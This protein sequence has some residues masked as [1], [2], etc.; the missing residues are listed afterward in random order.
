MFHLLLVCIC[1]LPNYPCFSSKLD[2]WN[3]CALAFMVMSV[4]NCGLN[5]FVVIALATLAIQEV[6]PSF[7]DFVFVTCC[8]CLTHANA[9]A[10]Q[11]P[12]YIEFWASFCA[13]L[14]LQF[15]PQGFQVKI[16]KLAWH[17]PFIHTINKDWAHKIVYPNVNLN[18]R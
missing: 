11:L 1:S 7:F 12:N 16:T 5:D 2:G 9:F 17:M 6:S 15:Q 10:P 13:T 14:N 18:G 8:G 3:R 4:Y